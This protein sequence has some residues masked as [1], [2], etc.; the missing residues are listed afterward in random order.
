MRLIN[1][2][3]GCIFKIYRYWYKDLLFEVKFHI[4]SQ[5]HPDDSGKLPSWY[6]NKP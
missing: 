2:N 4:V 1:C 6:H 3:M 5:Y